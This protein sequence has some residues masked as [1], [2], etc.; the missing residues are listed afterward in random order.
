MCVFAAGL[1]E[2]ARETGRRR[3]LCRFA[4]TGAALK[5]CTPFLEREDLVT[6]T[7]TK[8]YSE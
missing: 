2:A 1:Q 7:P 5:T 4:G 3:G 6:M 8:F